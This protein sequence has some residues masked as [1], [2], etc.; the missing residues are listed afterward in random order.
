MKVFS[1]LVLQLALQLV[2]PQSS[3]A[4]AAEAEVT[5]SLPYDAKDESIG[6]KQVALQSSAAAAT[7]D[8]GDSIDG[9]LLVEASEERIE[10]ASVG[11]KALLKLLAKAMRDEG[12]N[13][14]SVIHELAGGAWNAGTALPA[15]HTDVLQVAAE[16]APPAQCGEHEYK[17]KV[18]IQ[19]DLN[20]RGT[21]YSSEFVV[22]VLFRLP[23]FLL[24]SAPSLTPVLRFYRVGS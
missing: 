8:K 16:S 17:L 10:D 12:I 23:I 15:E 6:S 3:T 24:E 9:H 22:S 2:V 21:Y 20:S 11:V 1:S 13:D 19:T 5:P 14:E 18:E 7:D 4:A